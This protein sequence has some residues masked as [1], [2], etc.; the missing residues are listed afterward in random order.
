[1]HFSIELSQAL[2]LYKVYHSKM[3]ECDREIETQV[4]RFED[5]SDGGVPADKPGRRRSRD[6]SPNFDVRTHQYRLAG[7]DSYTALKV[8][9]EI[10]L[11][12]SRWP[13]VKHFGFVVRVDPRQQ[14]ERE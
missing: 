8:V 3:A 6:N 11:D 2:E 12:M 4:G 10:G 5:R 13:M 14:G 1:M 7:V 9:S